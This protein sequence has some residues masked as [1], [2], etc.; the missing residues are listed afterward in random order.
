MP[1]PEKYKTTK[2]N[3]MGGQV[4][5]T[6]LKIDNAKTKSQNTFMDLDDSQNNGVS[7][8]H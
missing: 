7:S 4:D 2:T 6:D 3:L 1:P 8:T 5:I